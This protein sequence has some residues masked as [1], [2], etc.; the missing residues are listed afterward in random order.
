MDEIVAVRDL[1]VHYRR[2]G[3]RAGLVRAVDGVSFS[4]SANQTLGLVG[5]SGSGKSTIGRA[6]LG[7]APIT[8]GEVVFAEE[9]SSRRQRAALLQAIFQDPYGTLDP[10]RR[11]GETL[12]EPVEAQ[13]VRGADARRSAADAIQR[14][15]LP[16]EVLDRFPHEFSGGQR[17]RIAIARALVV[18]PRLVVCDEPISAL[19]L[20]TQAS[21]LNLLKE[22][23]ANT[24]VSYL[25]VAHDLVAVNHLS[26]HVLVLY[27][28]RVMESGP[29]AQVCGSPLHPYSVALWTAAPVPDPTEQRRRRQLR[30]SVGA[31]ASAAAVST[32]S[33]GCPFA[34]RC[35]FAEAVCTTTRPAATRVGERTLECHMYDPGSG[36][37]AGGAGAQV[38][39]AAAGVT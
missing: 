37:S 8:S 26:D 14:V 18:R 12:R 4:V 35:A 25:F 33:A 10:L 7:L 2:R 16:A 38:V 29:A 15:G 23:Q 30:R 6:L 32:G 1:H 36:H 20:S 13:G 9:G 22:L 17:Q 27:R 3:W 28:G 24:G 19:D 34:A 21:V 11:I 39:A 5:E 31:T